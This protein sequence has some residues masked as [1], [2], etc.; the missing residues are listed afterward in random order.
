MYVV[1]MYVAG[2]EV[3]LCDSA[4]WDAD[5]VKVQ[6]SQHIE[7][8]LSLTSFLHIFHGCEGFEESFE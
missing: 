5:Y 6:I 1:N 4:F 3:R 8:S 2:C 7:G